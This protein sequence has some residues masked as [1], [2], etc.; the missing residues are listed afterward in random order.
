M[1]DRSESGS[2]REFTVPGSPPYILV[3]DPV[4]VRIP[5]YSLRRLIGSDN[6]I[7]PYIFVYDP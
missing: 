5:E 7:R 4:A 3:Y 2:D 1:I 6:R